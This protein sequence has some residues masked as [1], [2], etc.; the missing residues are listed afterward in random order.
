M[1]D[2]KKKLHM[3]FDPST[4]EH[5]GVR[6]YST[7]P[8][9]LAEL[10]ANSYDAG[11]SKVTIYLRDD[12]PDKS[13]VVED[14]GCGMTFDEVN[15]DFLTIG[16]NRRKSPKKSSNRAPI[17]KKGIGKLS[18][19]GVAG[20]FVVETKR[21]GKLTGFK[22]VHKKIMEKS[23]VGE[24]EPPQ[25]PSDKIVILSSTGTRI[26]LNKFKRKT[27]F[28]AEGV[29]GGLSKFFIFDDSFKVFVKRNDE[30]PIQIT[31][32]MRFDQID[33]EF[34]WSIPKDIRKKKLRDYF[35][36]KKIS[37]QILTGKK[38]ISPTTQMRGITLFSR[39]KLV[40]SPD[41]F[42]STGS[43]AY[44]SYQAG[45]LSVDFIETINEDVI[46]TDRQQLNWEHRDTIVLRKRIDELVRYVEQEWREK[47]KEKKKIEVTKKVTNT[48]GKDVEHWTQ[49]I[50]NVR[51]RERLIALLDIISD[52]VGVEEDTIDAV[53][54]K[55]Y[56]AI[57]EYADIIWPELHPKVRQ[58]AEPH[59]KQGFYADALTEAI[60]QYVEAIREKAG[61]NANVSETDV[62]QSVIGKFDVVR[63]YRK[64]N[65]SPFSESTY[66]NL[67]E[68]IKTTGENFWKI[69]NA[70]EHGTQRDIL[71]SGLISQRDC[72]D[73]LCYLSKLFRR[74]DDAPLK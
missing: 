35:T 13:V 31:N 55:V 51:I 1:A 58:V 40:N 42:G 29:A 25:I 68:V 69:R 28:S 56:E 66:G 23:D 6:L 54:E 43:S 34:F 65:N 7:L 48:T 57:P 41:H 10:V 39:T 30:G 8:P 32:Q 67:E 37:G 64:I 53:V 60:N 11:A 44:F 47:R 26:S 72:L 59:Y 19:F 45:F 15:S 49:S 12:G 22:M 38:P 2:E 33:P 16:R 62:L 5:L 50:F 71:G 52:L 24:Y 73:A 27:N 20:E 4:I 70:M 9:V 21:K 74:L 3:K 14:N 63:F 17:G 61:H 46:S 18:F 36:K